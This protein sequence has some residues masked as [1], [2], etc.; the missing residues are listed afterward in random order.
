[1]PAASAARA[2]ARRKASEEALDD[3]LLLHADNAVIRTGHANI[4]LERSTTREYPFVRCRNMGVG[5]QN[6]GYP[7]I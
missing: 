4:G 6:S 1:M 3:Q 5:A 2:P 7:S